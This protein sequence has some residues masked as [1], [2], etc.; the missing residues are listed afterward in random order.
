MRSPDSRVCPEVQL[1]HN[2]FISDRCGRRSACEAPFACSSNLS[3]PS[4]RYTDGRHACVA[5]PVLQSV[6]SSAEKCQRLSRFGCRLRPAQDTPEFAIEARERPSTQWNTS[7]LL[8]TVVA[9]G[10]LFQHTRDSRRVVSSGT[11]GFWLHPATVSLALR[12]GFLLGMCHS[13]GVIERP[14]ARHKQCAGSHGPLLQR[15]GGAS[16]FPRT[17]V[18]AIVKGVGVRLAPC[19]SLGAR[20][21]C[22]SAGPGVLWEV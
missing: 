7:D 16:L 2:G 9:L 15:V 10:R 17:L 11:Q 19:S 14:S 3:R 5:P 18:P 6:A 4:L 20:S 1:W 22:D 8:A 13:W 21:I 12:R